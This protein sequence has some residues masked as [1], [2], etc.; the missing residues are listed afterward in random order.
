MSPMTFV[1]FL[2]FLVG[3]TLAVVSLWADGRSGRHRAMAVCGLL[4]AWWAACMIPVYGAD[5]GADALLWYQLSIPGILLLIPAAYW[6]YLDQ[7]TW[8]PLWK[9]TATAAMTGFGIALYA[10]YWVDG[11]YFSDFRA[12]PWGNVGVVSPRPFWYYLGSTVYL[13]THT[14]VVVLMFRCRSRATSVRLRQLYAANGWGLLAT[15]VLFGAAFWLETYAGW[16]PLDM[17]AAGFYLVGVNF[18][19]MGRY[20]YLLREPALDV[21]QIGGQLTEAFLVLD[22]ALNIVTAN[23]RARQ[24]LGAGAS[25]GAPFAAL[26]LNSDEV[27]QGSRAALANPAS[28]PSFRGRTAE[29]ALDLSLSPCYDRFGDVSGAVAVASPVPGVPPSPDAGLT[30]RELEI[31]DLVLQGQDNKNIA[32]SLYVSLG[33]VKNHLYRLYKK[34]GVESRL[35]LMNRFR[36]RQ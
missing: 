13:V 23:P 34:V 31:L 1:A 27:D 18:Y 28:A 6:I 9:W 19:L 2:F 21:S 33:T 17:M 35:E 11:F 16:P 8:P 26:F 10:L 14:L 32:S 5:H 7:A 30:A 3:L 12:G 22:R 20:R 4:L 36:P 29:A 24:L 15:A 25:T